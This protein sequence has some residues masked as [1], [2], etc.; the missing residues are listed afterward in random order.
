MCGKV[1][2]FLHPDCAI[3]VY[4]ASSGFEA[5][6]GYMKAC[7]DRGIEP[8]Y[9]PPHIVRTWPWKVTPRNYIHD[10]E[11]SEYDTVCFAD[12]PERP[13]LYA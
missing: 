8:F 3:S 6:R 12:I 1:Y 10:A 11:R 4:G 2:T 9:C 5:M 7:A 13:A